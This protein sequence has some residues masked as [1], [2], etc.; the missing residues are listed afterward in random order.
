M[1][2][3]AKTDKGRGTCKG[4]TPALGREGK[5][6]A[7]RIGRSWRFDKE[8]ID[9]WIGEGLKRQQRLKNSKAKAAPKAVKVK[10]RKKKN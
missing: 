1:L 8:V 6:P 5:I 10:L 3:Y 4:S 9:R 7:I 2:V